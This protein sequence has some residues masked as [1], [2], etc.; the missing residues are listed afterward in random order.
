M[1]SGPIRWACA[2]RLV[3]MLRA[4]PEL[5]DVQVEPGFPGDKLTRAVSIWLDSPTGTL[6]VPVM[7]GGRRMVDDHFRL[8]FNFRIAG[9]QDL[10][11]AMDRMSALIDAAY[12]PIV[13]G[14]STLEDLDGVVSALPG[15]LNGPMAGETP[16]DGVLA[17]ASLVVDVHARIT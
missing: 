6:S 5:V 4:T 7:T 3:Q 14:T 17:F 11:D 12:Q 13:D 15:E 10:A 8:P 16:A 1:A 2:Q 9:A